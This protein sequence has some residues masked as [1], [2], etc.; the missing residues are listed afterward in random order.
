MALLQ[1]RLTDSVPAGVDASVQI[2]T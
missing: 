1:A 2:E